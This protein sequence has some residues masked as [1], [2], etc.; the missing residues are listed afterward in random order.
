MQSKKVGR[1]NSFQDTRPTRGQQ[2]PD[3]LRATSVATG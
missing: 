1:S 2:G 3:W